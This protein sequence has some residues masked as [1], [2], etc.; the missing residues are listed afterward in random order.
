MILKV[1]REVKFGEIIL[2][3]INMV[4]KVMWLDEIMKVVNGDREN[5]E[6]VD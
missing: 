1:W 2:G 4:F 5:I 6:K 3:V